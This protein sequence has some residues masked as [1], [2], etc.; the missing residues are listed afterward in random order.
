MKTKSFFT[1]DQFT[2]TQWDAV[3]VKAEFANHLLTFILQE[4]PE[5]MF[6]HKFYDRLHLTF[7]FIA[8]YNREGFKDFWFST[9]ATKADFIE[10]LCSWPCWGDPQFTYSDVERAVCAKIAELNLLAA[11]RERQGHE[12]HNRELATLKRLQEKYQ[13]ATVVPVPEPI[14]IETQTGEQLALIA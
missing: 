12:Q 4:F 14:T 5:A 7:G 11:W 6:T 1:A 3:E 13:P 9:T 2:A 10:A 8:H